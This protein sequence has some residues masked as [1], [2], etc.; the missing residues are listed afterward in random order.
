MNVHC[1]GWF[2]K[3][4]EGDDSL[5]NEGQSSWPL[6]FDNN[7]LREITEVDPLQSH[8]KLPQNSMLTNGHSAFEANWKVK[9]LDKWI[10]HELSK[11]QKKNCCSEVSCSLILCNNKTF[12]NEIVT[13][14]KRWILYDNRRQP[15]QWLDWKEA[16]KHFPKPNLNQKKVMVTVWWSAASL[17]HY[18][19]LNSSATI[20]SEKYAQQIKETHWKLQ[21]LQPTLVTR[22][23]PVLFHDNVRPHVTQPISASGYEVLPHPLYL[24]DLSRIG[25][26]FKHRNN[27]LQ[28]KCFHKQQKQKM[29]SRRSLNS[30]AW[31]FFC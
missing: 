15:T 7:Q 24:P 17:I 4:C 13:C 19:F 3:F 31:I 18:S 25:Y 1:G 28:G 14:N 11:Y 22:E 29:V 23:G 2:K 9:K 20:T 21:H 30:T 26:L 27:C 5:D 8:K 10:S 16:P 12:L 6:E